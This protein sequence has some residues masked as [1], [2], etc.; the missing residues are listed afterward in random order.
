MPDPTFVLD[1]A[2]GLLSVEWNGER[3][4]EVVVSTDLIDGWVERHNALVSERNHL[5]DRVNEIEEKS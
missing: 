1:P 3:P 5:F 4:D 2:T